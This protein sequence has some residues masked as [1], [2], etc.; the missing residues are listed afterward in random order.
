MQSR[1]DRIPSLAGLQAF[2]AA[3][4]HLS[5][6]RAAEELG[7]T[8]TAI[9]HRIRNL[10]GELGVTLFR[11]GHRSV[12]LTEDGEQ[13]AKDLSESFD[14]LKM[15]VAKLRRRTDS[16]LRLSVA[17]SFTA[18]WLLPRLPEFRGRHP[19]IDLFIDPSA[20]LPCFEL[21]GSDAVIAFGCGLPTGMQSDCLFMN[22]LVPVCS[23]DFLA[24]H[25]SA[26]F[27]AELSTLPLLHAED[28]RVAP[29]LPGWRDWF[30][31][32]GISQLGALDGPTFG[33]CHLV[34]EA[35]RLGQG[36]ALGLSTLIAD[37]LSAGALVAPFELSLPIPQTYAL[38]YPPEHARRP[39]LR[40]FRAWLLGYAHRRMGSMPDHRDPGG[41]GERQATAVPSSLA[42][43][44]S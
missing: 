15:S 6:T 34:I 42:K 24:E 19:S 22:R 1:P 44:A 28:S 17:P 13:V 25:G 14:C 40:A 3:A 26:D 37:D 4:R 35:A 11:R 30:K 31:A 5:F 16:Q 32:A 10:E 12:T 39:A 23:P 21:N 38:I 8:P 9:S 29:P 41:I 2:E 43:G 20:E 27:Q 36:L 7:L 18:R 33:A